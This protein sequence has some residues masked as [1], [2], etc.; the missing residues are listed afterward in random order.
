MN[1]QFENQ[2]T[3]TY[4]VYKIEP[5]DVLDSM[6]LGM[7]TN[8][9]IPGFAP[10]I[11]TQMDDAKYIKFNVSSKVSVNQFF[12][13]QVN[14]K[15]LLGVFRGIMN[16]MISAE[17]YMIDPNAIVMDL[18]Y[19]F[20]DVST[21]ETVLIC[22]P[23]NVGMKEQV[24][25][26]K[27]FKNIMFSTQFDQTEN[28]DHVAKIINFLNSSPSFSALN[29][30]NLLDELERE[31]TKEPASTQPVAAPVKQAPVQQPVAT[32]VPRQAAPGSAA[33]S[34]HAATDPGST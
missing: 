1:V 27:F 29:F 6:S 31:G 25:I 34:T 12:S 18:E 8:N 7:I 24:D 14:K 2:G 15:R 22:L 19:V 32:E 9:K 26:G 3:A 21:C 28:C 11:F 16:A 20:A 5:D 30:K 33:G 10:A 4:L 13:G 17:D 23:I